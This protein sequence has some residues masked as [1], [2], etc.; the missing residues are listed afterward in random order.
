MVFFAR[1]LRFSVVILFAGAVLSL[2][3]A[4]P[5][6]ILP[7]YYISQKRERDPASFKERSC[8]TPPPPP[9]MLFRFC[10]GGS[11]SSAESQGYDGSGESKKTGEGSGME[12]EADP[13]NINATFIDRPERKESFRR[14]SIKVRHTPDVIWK[15]LERHGINE[16]S[17][18]LRKMISTRAQK[19]LDDLA[20]VHLGGGEKVPDP[21]GVLHDMAP[22]IPAIRQSPSFILRITSATSDVDAGAAAC[23]IGMIARLCELY[24]KKI[25]GNSDN[26]KSTGSVIIKDRR[27]EQLVECVLC[28]VD[29][30][31]RRR[32]GLQMRSE[33]ASGT[34]D[35]I[36][37]LL[38]G[39]SGTFDEG[40]TVADSCR[41]AWGLSMLGGYNIETFGDE[42]THDILIALS[43]LTRELLLGRLKK[44]RQGEVEPDTTQKLSLTQR[45]NRDAEALAE[46]A[47]AAMWTFACVKACTGLRSVPLFETCCSILCQD[48]TDLRL[49]AQEKKSGFDDSNFEVN[50]VVERLALSETQT[51]SDAAVEPE[52]K[53]PQ[54]GNDSRGTL[55][56]WLS[57]NEVTD[58]IWSLAL[59]GSTD[60]IR[61]LQ[62]KK[63]SETSAIF[64]EVAFDRLR[65]WLQK[66]LDDLQQAHSLEQMFKNPEDDQVVLG[67]GS[68][69]DSTVIE[70][71]DASVILAMERS[72]ESMVPTIENISVAG[73]VEEVQV[74]DAASL[75]AAADPASIPRVETEIIVTS[76]TNLHRREHEDLTFSSHNLCAIAW[77]VT[78]LNDPL[79]GNI[80]DAIVNILMLRGSD[81]SSGLVGGNLAN[82]AWS[83]AKRADIENADGNEIDATSCLAITEWITQQALALGIDN[84]SEF[85]AS[86]LLKHLQPPEIGRLMW[87]IAST[88]TILV[89]TTI[90]SSPEASHLAALCLRVAASNLAVF[91]TEDL[92]SCIPNGSCF[93]VSIP[94]SHH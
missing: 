21:L 85:E 88:T 80:V 36:E 91:G 93:P 40:L 61:L 22:K 35:D 56:D 92:V 54:A 1:P 17:Y 29:V 14:S 43:L 8:T 32:E 79:Q 38:D 86:K 37:T 24:D 41:A 19:Y 39:E 69:D 49:R 6:Q 20:M 89:D 84:K 58:A 42:N 81:R 76:S 4:T 63:L 46:D 72:S 64:R 16:E 44:L 23:A 9:S 62:P 50:D 75:L 25:S 67:W 77:A 26:M 82:L 48:P 45:F 65:E 71:V 15:L 27:F 30:K 87:S 34:E 78:D 10:R 68:S 28:G 74:V 73:S 12:N 3:T 2:V 66:D 51:V 59:H 31:M 83:I 90:N 11:S 13:T 57:P 70:V 18:D 7:R 52:M 55:I 5:K 33:T 53:D 60:D 47:A 94:C